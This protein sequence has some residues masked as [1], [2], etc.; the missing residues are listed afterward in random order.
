MR[1]DLDADASFSKQ[2]RAKQTECRKFS[3]MIDA[4]IAV[5]N[6]VGKTG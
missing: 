4:S 3:K 5:Q 6:S 1:S 2:N